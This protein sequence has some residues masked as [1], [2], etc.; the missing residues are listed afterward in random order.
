[1]QS[2]G[3]DHPADGE[4]AALM[5]TCQRTVFLC[6]MSVVGNAEDAED[7]VQE[8]KLV[9]WKKFHDFQ[10]GT[11][12]VAWAC[13]ITRYQALK[14]RASRRRQPLSLANDF[15]ALWAVPGNDDSLAQLERRRIALQEC[16]EELRD[17]DKELV[18]SRY[19]KGATT[20]NVAESLQRSVQG[21]RRALQ[22]V[23]ETL[24]KCVGRKIAQEEAE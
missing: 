23:R 3:S 16:L 20:R 21:T 4:F 7:V 18:V 19:R 6:A 15:L 2:S 1:M 5:S 24:A 12:F 11:N 10:P 13:Q 22:R 8:S 9:M 17:S 14:V